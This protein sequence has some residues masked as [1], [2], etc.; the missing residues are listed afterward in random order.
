MANCRR[1]CANNNADKHK[2]AG[3]IVTRI[4][5]RMILC[6][7]EGKETC[8][9]S[10][11]HVHE[12]SVDNRSTGKVSITLKARPVFAVCE[13]NECGLGSGDVKREIKVID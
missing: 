2:N 1:P 3:D 9:S 8:H 5:R 10:V 4:A 11:A 12:R 6:K 13:D 7:K